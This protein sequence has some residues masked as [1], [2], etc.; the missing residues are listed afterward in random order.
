MKKT[1]FITGIGGQDG[2]YL[3]ELLLKKNYKVY[4]IIRRNSVVEHQKNRIDHLSKNLDI[5]YGDLLNES[6]ISQLLKKIKPR[7]IYNLAAQSHVRISFDLPEFTAKT[8]AI[9]V[10][11]LLQAY[12][13]ESPNSKFY[14]ASSSEMFGRSVDKDGFQRE[15]TPFEP[16]SPYGCSKVF[17]YNLVKHYRFAYKLFACNGILFN[18][19]SPRRGSNFVTNKVV[20]NSVKIS[21]GLQKLLEVGNIHSYRDWGHAK[22]YVRAMNKILN[23]KKADD[24]VIATGKA[25]SVGQMI[26]YVF[27][28]LKLSKKKHLR[29]NKKFFRPE[30]L[31]YLQGDSSKARKLLNWKPEHTFENML[32][33]MIDYWINF[34]KKNKNLN[35]F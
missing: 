32:N 2:S 28:K 16:T 13:N 6:S 25:R 20:K 17:A 7:E 27:K 8:N 31:K 21:L 5:V 35:D 1:A 24:W 15:T 22:D 10:L 18:H 19:E 14:Q 33:E 34:Y 12:K 4:G 23:Y 11:N 26:D 29:I 9:G 30:E 3:C